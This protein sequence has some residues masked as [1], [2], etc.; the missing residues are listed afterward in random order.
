MKKISVLLLITVMLL[1]ACTINLS[2]K[3]VPDLDSTTWTMIAV[4]DQKAL[5]TSVVFISFNG[6]DVSGSG[7]CNHFGGGVTK[8]MNGNMEFGML[9]MTEMYCVKEGI[10]DQEYVFLQALS[11]VNTYYVSGGNLMMENADGDVILEFT[12]QSQTED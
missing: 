5:P 2:S 3:D 12:Q 9:F 8:D 6:Q 7:G 11:E 10:S 4:K 1:S